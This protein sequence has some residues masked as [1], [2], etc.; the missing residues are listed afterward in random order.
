MCGKHSA[1]DIHSPSRVGSSPSVRGTHASAARQ[2][3][4]T[5][6]IPACAGNTRVISSRVRPSRDHPRM[7]GEHTT[8]DSFNLDHMGSSPHVRGTLYIGKPYDVMAGIIP[9]CAGNTSG[10][11]R[12]RSSRRDHPRVCGEHFA[13]YGLAFWTAGSSPRVRGTRLSGMCITAPTD[14]PRVCGEHYH[15]SSWS[16]TVRGSSP[17]V[18]GTP[19]DDLRGNAFS[20]IIPACAGNTSWTT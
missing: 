9:A 15:L 3:T 12:R 16:W 6:I 11:T 7:C 5:G 19:P 20:R 8:D 14:H 13:K 2:I 10:R 1:L 17:R 18:R 4:G